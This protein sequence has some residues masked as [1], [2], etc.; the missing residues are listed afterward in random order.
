MGERSF[1]RLVL[2]CM[3]PLPGIDQG[4]HYFIACYLGN[5]IVAERG[6]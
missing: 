3:I 1:Y 5:A 2:G 6:E 4:Y